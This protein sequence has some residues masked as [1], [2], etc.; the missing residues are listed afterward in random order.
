M[1]NIHNMPEIPVM[2]VS[3]SSGTKKP[4]IEHFLKQFIE[5]I[6]LLTNNG[7]QINDVRVDVVVR[8]IIADSPCW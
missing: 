1:I 4:S 6:N 3:I 2:I 7:V 5:E 8:A